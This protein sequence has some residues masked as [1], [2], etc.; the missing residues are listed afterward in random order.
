LP[1]DLQRR[2]G[3]DT[4]VWEG[5]RL[6][7]IEQVAATASL[8]DGWVLELADLPASAVAELTAA[9]VALSTGSG[10]PDALLALARSHAPHGLFTGHLEKGSRELDLVLE[11][12]ALA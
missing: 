10:D 12:Q 9:Y 4:V 8:V 1:Y 2:A 6:C 5:R 11:R 3:G 7:C